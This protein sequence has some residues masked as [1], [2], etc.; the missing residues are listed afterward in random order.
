M[1]N[2]IDESV[3]PECGNVPED[4]PPSSGVPEYEG[5]SANQ[6]LQVN[7][8]P[9]VEECT[10]DKPHCDLTP[11]QQRE[12]VLP[13]LSKSFKTGDSWF[14]L[15]KSWYDRWCA[16]VGHTEFDDTDDVVD[17]GA[18]PPGVIDN[19]EIIDQSFPQA[20]NVETSD[21][22]IMIHQE[23][24]D[25]IVPWYGLKEGSLIERKV[26][27]V[28][29]N[30]I[31]DKFPKFV[32]VWNCN[33]ETVKPDLS[34]QFKFD[35][36]QTLMTIAQ[37]MAEELDVKIDDDDIR[38]S[39][40]F[41]PES[42]NDDDQKEVGD[43]KVTDAAPE[44]WE[45]IHD[46]DMDARLDQ[47][48]RMSTQTVFLFERKKEDGK[49]PR[50]LDFD[51]DNLRSCI[52][53]GDVIDAQDTQSKWYQSVIMFVKE[54]GFRVHFKGWNPKW[55]E[56]F[57]WDNERVA[58]V[59]TYTL[60][61]HK[62]LAQFTRSMYGTWQ[63]LSDDVGGKPA[64]RGLVGLCNLGN[65]CFM[66]SVL[67]CLFQS[68]PFR[69]YFLRKRYEKDINLDNPLGWNGNVANSWGSLTEKIWG[70][71]YKTVA[72]KSFKKA[73][74]KV[75]PRFDGYQQQDS[76][77]FLTFL[78]DG[79]HEDLNRIKN[80]PATEN[81]ES[82]GTVADSEIATKSWD[83]FKLRNDSFMVNMLYGQL[84]NE[85]V[86]PKCAT[87][88][89]VF[90]PFTFLQ[91]PLPVDNLRE[92]PFTF[93]PADQKIPPKKDK[94]KLSAVEFIRTFKTKVAERVGVKLINLRFYEV[95]KNKWY[96]PLRRFNDLE[97]IRGL[98]E[99]ESFFVYEVEPLTAEEEIDAAAREEE[100]KKE[101]AEGDTILAEANDYKYYQGVIASIEEPSPDLP[102]SDQ[103]PEKIYSVQFKTVKMR[104]EGSRRFRKVVSKPPKIDVCI[105]HFCGSQQYNRWEA[106]GMPQHLHL[107][108]RQLTNHEVLE[109]VN[110]KIAPYVR[111]AEAF[112]IYWKYAG[113][114]DNSVKLVDD[115]DPFPISKFSQMG[116]VSEIHVYWTDF[117]GYKNEV[118]TEV[119]ALQ[120]QESAL[121]NTLSIH[122]CIKKYCETEVLDDMNMVYCRKCKEHQNSSK[123]TT[124]WRLPDQLII[125]FKRFSYGG[126]FADK[127]KTPV[128]FPLTNLDLSSY[129][130]DEESKDDCIYDLYG[131]SNHSGFLAG[132][133]YTAYVKSLTNGKWYE[134][135]DTNV[136]ELR[137]LSRISSK[138]AYLVF[139]R[140][141]KKG[142]AAP[143]SIPIID[144][145]V[146]EDDERDEEMEEPPMMSQKDGI[147]SY[148]GTGDSIADSGNV[149]V[150][151]NGLIN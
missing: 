62:P 19:T 9:T 47:I 59:G 149:G 23:T 133:H 116:S 124:I 48:P 41:T 25:M 128:S 37:K 89:I 64:V 68:G 121:S 57:P 24:W 76:Q 66:N 45:P 122:A 98:K 74:G 71:K 115:N 108:T 119:H 30:P 82:D 141:R 51:K 35:S 28:N 91:L 7:E 61:P 125:H 17:K 40:K 142:E 117:E 39:F 139:Y 69:S 4:F 53:P 52:R 46:S 16:Y 111:N 22:A 129:V 43:E 95:F 104:Y 131:V 94:I 8:L 60:Q 21:D 13:L 20:L 33:P 42:D 101:Y 63:R 86:C 148:P 85:V 99:N 113:L 44:F 3:M 56:T 96:Q 110:E 11:E 147:S 87:T 54:E 81:P 146:I 102:D 118:E 83:T 6:P 34:H 105:K 12:K 136:T 78:L 5:N 38:L 88:S 10:A 103:K 126:D 72:P 109:L 67:Q 132:G 114:I 18:P 137:D 50:D 93:V 130:M 80:K 65:T 73:I 58:A 107:P 31:V 92:I 90:D 27:E 79:L 29:G 143:V 97:S 15:A 112:Q 120:R 150:I 84:K 144:T 151:Y 138:R 14:A 26:I 1:D 100:L 140:K 145:D 106:F 49:F 123:T 36:A 127:V 32:K 75:A 55:D 134:M 77:E 70:D 2:P 135:D